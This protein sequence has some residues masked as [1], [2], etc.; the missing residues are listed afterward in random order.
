M[1]SLL[2]AYLRL[3]PRLGRR[4]TRDIE[5]PELNLNWDGLRIDNA[6][7]QRY[8]DF[9][10]LKDA[11]E[12][13][14]LH[15][16]YCYILGQRAQL[17]LLAHR[18]FPFPAAGLVHLS[19]EVELLR[20]FVMDQPYRLS[21]Q[22]RRTELSRS[23]HELELRS[24]FHQDGELVAV[25]RTLARAPLPRQ[26]VPPPADCS[27]GAEAEGIQ[28]AAENSAQITPIRRS[29]NHTPDPVLQ[30]E[31]SLVMPAWAGQ[32]YARVSGDYNPVHLKPWMARRFGFR[33]PIAHGMYSLMRVVS[34]VERQ[35]GMQAQRIQVRF[36]R[37]VFLPSIS[38]LGHAYV[39][40]RCHF[41]LTD[42]RGHLQ[43]SGSL[44]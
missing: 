13:T 6:H 5:V 16:I 9:F 44:S 37:P 42:A 1:A 41:E 18:D 32:R 36:H 3:L 30:P 10:S 14:R 23:G 24:E 43:L 35:E 15:P 7:Y 29:H 20:P 17:E 2:L 19:N 8:L 21:L 38:S 39:G 27:T 26:P 31:V 22:A 33:H 25:N 11:R 4:I 12:T 28:P 34:V 40:T